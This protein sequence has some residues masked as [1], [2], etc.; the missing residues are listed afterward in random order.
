MPDVGPHRFDESRFLAAVEELDLDAMASFFFGCAEPV[1]PV[2]HMH[3][4]PVDQYRRPLGFTL[5]QPLGVLLI[6]SRETR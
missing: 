5:G 2:D 1:H 4:G 3:G 6:L